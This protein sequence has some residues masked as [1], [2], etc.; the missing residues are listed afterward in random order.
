MRNHTCRFQR[1]TATNNRPF[2]FTWSGLPNVYVTGIEYEECKCGRVAGIFPAPLNL[3][4]VL[5]RTVVTKR[6]A[7][8]GPEIRYLRKTMRKKAADF[9]QLVGVSPEQVSRWETERNAPEKP[10]DKLI[11]LMA[12]PTDE[13]SAITELIYMGRPLKNESYLLQFNRTWRGTHRTSA[14]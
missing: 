3:L 1:K 9:A 7:L 10:A 6:S 12:S 14:R 4:T 8:T 2:L 13:L 11:R 5:T